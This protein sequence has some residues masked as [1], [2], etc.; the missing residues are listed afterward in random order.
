MYSRF[1]PFHV[2]TEPRKNSGK[3]EVT[4]V[5]THIQHIQ[6]L[7]N[8]GEIAYIPMTAYHTPPTKTNSVETRNQSQCNQGSGGNMVLPLLFAP[9]PQKL[10]GR[11]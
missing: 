9:T 2:L 6:K 1:I 11:S 3:F 10:Q 4:Y 7:D 5:K 8:C